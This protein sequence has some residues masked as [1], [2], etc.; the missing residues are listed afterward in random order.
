M[1]NSNKLPK[2]LPLAVL[3]LWSVY[4][5]LLW[6]QEGSRNHPQVL[7]FGSIT[8][9]QDER[10]GMLLERQALLNERKGGIDGYRI[11]VFFNSGRQAREEA[12]KVKAELLSEFPG[13]P[14]YVVYHAPFYKVRVGDFRN[15]YE[16]LGTFRQIRKKY[17]SAYIVKDVIPFPNLR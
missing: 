5:G 10:V 13:L 7:H 17:F 8:L 11:Q 2:S 1:Q 9:V 4:S 14:V 15:K 12:L 3:M 6:A 16:A